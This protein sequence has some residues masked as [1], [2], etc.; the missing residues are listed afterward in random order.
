MEISVI[1]RTGTKIYCLEKRRHKDK[2]LIHNWGEIS[3]E[4][5]MFSTPLCH[6]GVMSGG[7]GLARFGVVKA[8]SDLKEVSAQRSI[9]VYIDRYLLVAV[10]DGAVVSAS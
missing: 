10:K 5:K 2:A 1:Q 3:T 4:N 6:I 7:T 9:G 8:L